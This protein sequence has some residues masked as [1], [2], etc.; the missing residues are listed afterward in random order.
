MWTFK[1]WM[2]ND[3]GIGGLGRKGVIYCLMARSRCMRYVHLD[4]FGVFG[5]TYTMSSMFESSTLD[6]VVLRLL[7]CWIT[8]FT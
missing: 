7:I 5:K 4:R 8:T 1:Y 6:I 2:L 3:Y